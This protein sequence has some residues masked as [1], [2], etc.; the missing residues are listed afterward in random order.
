M[1][2]A[3]DNFKQLTEKDKERLK[4]SPLDKEVPLRESGTARSGRSKGKPEPVSA[5]KPRSLFQ[6]PPSGKKMQVPEDTTKELADGAVTDDEESVFKSD[7]EDDDVFDG[8]FRLDNKAHN[9]EKLEIV[10]VTPAVATSVEPRDKAPSDTQGEEAWNSLPDDLKSMLE[11]I[12][13]E[14]LDRMPGKL[15][16]LLFCIECSVRCESRRLFMFLSS[17]PRNDL[18]CFLRILLE[19][20]L[21]YLEDAKELLCDADSVG[22]CLPSATDCL[23]C[24]FQLC[25]GC[26][27]D[28]AVPRWL[29]CHARR[30]VSEDRPEAHPPRQESSCCMA[31]VSEGPLGS[32]KDVINS[33]K[34]IIPSSP[35]GTPRWDPRSLHI[36]SVELNRAHGFSKSDHQALFER[37]ELLRPLNLSRDNSKPLLPRPESKLSIIIKEQPLSPPRAQNNKFARPLS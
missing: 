31:R 28:L 20:D 14:L 12:E 36:L 8:R 2:E 1:Q 17:D 22:L 9:P 10:P 29:G 25:L 11:Q 37:N 26:N 24:P 27:P 15:S 4:E 34:I 7:L 16:K 18:K 3:A 33:T 5:Q 19:E 35:R 6:T 32:C 30:R 21:R 23:D 13:P